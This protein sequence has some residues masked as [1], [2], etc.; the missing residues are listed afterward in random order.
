MAAYPATAYEFFARSMQKTPDAPALEIRGQS[1]SY[2]ELGAAV[3]VTVNAMLAKNP[4]PP[5]RIALCAK[6]SG[7]LFGGYLAIQAAG[8][9]VVPMDPTYPI[10]RCMDILFRCRVGMALVDE[11]GAKMFEAV[12]PAERPALVPLPDPHLARSDG[13]LLERNHVSADDEV[14]VLFTSGSTGRPKGVPIRQ[15]NFTPLVAYMI[16]RYDL[17]PGC[18]YAQTFSQMFDP[19]MA[20]IF[21]TWGAGGTVV[22][23][24][25]DELRTIATFMAKRAVTHWFSVSSTVSLAHAAGELW[26]GA[27]P[28]LE[29]G[30]FGAE[31][32]TMN[33][34]RLWHDMAPNAQILNAY[35]PTETVLTCAD[36]LLPPD[37][38][39]WPESSNGTVPIGAVYPH[40]DY[41]IIAEDGAEASEGEL[42]IRGV[43]RFDG[44][45][46]AK[47]N[48]GRFYAFEPGG[49][50]QV[51]T[52]PT[53]SPAHWYRTGDY[54][55]RI[56]GRLVHCGRIDNQ[57]KVLGH[58]IEPGEIEAVMRR[59]PNVVDAVVVRCRST[60]DVLHAA[61]TGREVVDA[62]M[63]EWLRTSLP[64]F[65]VPGSYRYYEELP[66]NLVGKI[67][68]NAIEAAS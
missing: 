13:E 67:D 51:V 64:A 25:P 5:A 62:D 31:P 16:D 60:P 2:R 59:H 7:A 3:S 68:R 61:Y 29:Y 1:Y 57:M 27:A 38:A 11:A 22:D 33:Q 41:A 34:A 40:L 39:L 53:P 18:R 20:N 52:D 36:E 66:K 55:K 26:P 8:R 50:A 63:A 37:T 15:R 48:S 12:D 9:S 23:V 10:E 30:I 28:D 4:N 65:M 6:R 35:G 56:D 44:Y 14:Y 54:I 17:R 46:E 32:F 19:F 42:C 58:R 45:L 43:Q 47:D 49:R 21:A 24:Q